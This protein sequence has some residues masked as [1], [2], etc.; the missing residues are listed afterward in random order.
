M[1]R[2][3]RLGWFLEVFD[4]VESILVA[5]DPT[6]TASDPTPKGTFRVTSK[7][8]NK[9][10]ISNPGAGYPMPN[11]VEFK[12]A[13]GFHGGWIHPYPASHGCIRLPWKVSAKLFNLV[14]PGTP[15]SISTSQPYDAQYARTVSQPFWASSLSSW[16]A[17][18][19]A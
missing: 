4:Q 1:D 6:G 10:R 12:P 8:A 2:T 17:P 11:W 3:L 13:Y 19:P 14:R 15:I 18:Q 5:Y 9:R 7:I 16:P